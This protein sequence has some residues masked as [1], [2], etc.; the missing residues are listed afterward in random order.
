MTLEERIEQLE[1]KIQDMEV[2]HKSEDEEFI[3][4]S[5]AMSQTAKKS[6]QELLSNQA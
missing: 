6:I 1:K 2:R 3:R 4:V 5:A